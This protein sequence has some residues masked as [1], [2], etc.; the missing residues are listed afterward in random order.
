MKATILVHLE[1]FF[2]EL[3]R[4]EQVLM[5]MVTNGFDGFLWSFLLI[6]E[7]KVIYMDISFIELNLSLTFV[8]IDCSND[9]RWLKPAEF[10]P[11][12]AETFARFL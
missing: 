9:E 12:A 11:D 3:L 10:E 2:L 4:D 5:S 7:M 6:A 8:K 1:M